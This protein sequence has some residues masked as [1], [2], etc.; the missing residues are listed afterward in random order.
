[1]YPSLTQVSEP[2]TNRSTTHRTSSGPENHQKTLGY[3]Q[4]GML[5]LGRRKGICKLTV[6]QGG[7]YFTTTWF[8]MAYARGRLTETNYIDSH[9][10]SFEP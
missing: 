2:K 8:S 4:N 9:V 7:P 10:A 6:C 3:S 1:M 5:F